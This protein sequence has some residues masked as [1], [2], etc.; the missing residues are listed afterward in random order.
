MGRGAYDTS[1]ISKTPLPTEQTKQEEE[2][3]NQK[4]EHTKREDEQ[5]PEA[6]ISTSEMHSARHVI[7]IST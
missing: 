6:R 5:C 7:A 4:E 3:T 2:H 1:C